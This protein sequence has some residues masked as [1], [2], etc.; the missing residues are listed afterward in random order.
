MLKVIIVDD[1]RNNI[2]VM[3]LLLEQYCEGVNIVATAK[4]ATEA[5]DKIIY[6]QP[7]L[8]FLD[9]QMPQHSGFDLLRMFQGNVFFEVVFVTGFDQ[10]AI[11]AI[12]FSALDYLLKPVDIE[13]LKGAVEKARSF[14]HKNNSRAVENN[15]LVQNFQLAEMDRNIIIHDK[16]KVTVVKAGEIEVIQS[17][18]RYSTLFMENGSQFVMAK[19]LKEFEDYFSENGPFV[20]VSRSIMLNLNFLKTYTKGETCIIEMRSGKSYEVSRRRKQ[21]ILQKIKR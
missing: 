20:R 12:K 11:S 17:E 1:E 5:Y 10:Y 7:D 2:E 21:E 4:S 8:I 19:N 3:Q 13:E 14:I 18:G 16:E 9:I 6:H 15:N